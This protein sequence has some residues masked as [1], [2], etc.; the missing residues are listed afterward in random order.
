MPSKKEKH[1]KSSNSKS[2][3][4]SK[5]KSSSSHNKESSRRIEEPPVENI[6]HEEVEIIEDV[7]P[8]TTQDGEIKRRRR[9]VDKESVL[10]EFDSILQDFEDEIQNLRSTDSK[11]RRITGVKFL[12]SASKRI[13]TLKN[14]ASRCMKTRKVST[15]PRNTTSGFMKPVNISDEMCKFTGWE[16][17]CPKSRVDVTKYICSYIK[18]KDLQN[19]TD[20]RIIL[21]DGKL[22]K[23]LNIQKDEE[24]PLTYYTLQKRIQ[25]HFSKIES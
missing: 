25:H 15:R 10:A 18:K 6:T 4:S 20:R 21:P 7:A 9:V 3:R 16:S 2:E 19:P 17:D 1:H 11:S 13:R 5:K 23:L 22:K 14:D 8:E 24:D 12:R